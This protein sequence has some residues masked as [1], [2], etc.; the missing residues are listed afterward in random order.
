MASTVRPS[1]RVLTGTGPLSESCASPR[2]SMTGARV[3]PDNLPEAASAFNVAIS[4]SLAAS[5]R[6]PLSLAFAWRWPRRR[7]AISSRNAAIAVFLVGNPCHCSDGDLEV[8]RPS[9]LVIPNYGESISQ[10]LG[11]SVPATTLTSGLVPQGSGVFIST[12]QA[13]S[14]VSLAHSIRTTPMG[15]L[16][17]RRAATTSASPEVQG[18]QP[19]PSVWHNWRNWRTIMNVHNPME[20]AIDVLCSR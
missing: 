9:V 11:G 13:G 8:F 1:R 17:E 7:R 19:A 2:A 12:T 3:A 6:C 10:T 14:P 4:A 16:R 15:R 5:A 18:S 20:S